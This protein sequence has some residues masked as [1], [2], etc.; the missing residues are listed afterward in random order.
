MQKMLSKSL[1]MSTGISFAF[2]TG[3]A[4]IVDGEHQSISVQTPPTM[5]AT[6][7]LT[8]NKGEWFIPETPGSVVVHKSYD[9]LV[10]SCQEP[11]YVPDTVD[12]KS[13]TKAMAF[14]NVIFGGAIGAGVDVAD[15]AA[16]DYPVNV[17]VPMR[18]GYS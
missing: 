11:G 14:G 13:H 2:L 10:V 18:R 16:Y 12:V 17:V 7:S 5:G 9:D 15:G 8:N 1:M 3:C 4:S 6:C